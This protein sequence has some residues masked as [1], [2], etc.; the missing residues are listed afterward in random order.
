MR[1][2]AVV[3]FRPPS[4]AEQMR[5]RCRRLPLLIL[6]TRTRSHPFSKYHTVRGDPMPFHHPY[7]SSASRS[8]AFATNVTQLPCRR[9][10]DPLPVGSPSPIINRQPGCRPR[11]PKL[12]SDDVQQDIRSSLLVLRR[13]YLLRLHQSQTAPLLVMLTGGRLKHRGGGEC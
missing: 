13:P 5:F 1:R 11:L 3:S 4:A 7:T 9:V 8:L 10:F 2:L 6:G 12:T